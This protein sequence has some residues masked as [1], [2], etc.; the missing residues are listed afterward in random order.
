MWKQVQYVKNEE[1]ICLIETRRAGCL[2]DETESSCKLSFPTF[3]YFHIHFGKFTEP[4][5]HTFLSIKLQE[6]FRVY[7]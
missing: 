3:I 7:K 4:P 1:P 5:N 2:S 6:Q